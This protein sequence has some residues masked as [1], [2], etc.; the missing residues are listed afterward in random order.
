MSCWSIMLPQPAP[1]SAPLLLTTAHREVRFIPPRRCICPRLCPMVSGQR[2][3][4][5]GF[6]R[7]H[8]GRKHPGVL[9]VARCC[10]PLHDRNMSIGRWSHIS[11][12]SQCSYSQRNSR[13]VWAQTVSCN[14]SSYGSWS[15]HSCAWAWACG[16]G[17]AIRLETK[18]NS[19]YLIV[20][21]VHNWCE[22][23]LFV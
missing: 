23:Y 4:N 16:G 6:A 21:C 11:T 8:S 7:S 22:G 15:S 18:E 13:A 1:W 9:H 3:P 14:R 2:L 10:T 19:E 12:Y 20:V 17:G 5:L